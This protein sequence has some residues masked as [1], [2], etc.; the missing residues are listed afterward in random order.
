MEIEMLKQAKKELGYTYKDISRLSG[1]PLRTI[2]D[3]FAE[4]TKPR[5]DTVEA[6][7]KALGITR[8]SV[9]EETKT[10]GFKIFNLKELRK[11]MHKTQQQVANDL[12]IV[13][14][15]YQQYESGKYQPDNE[16]LLKIANYF[17]VSIDYLF[18]RTEDRQ[19]N[20]IKEKGLSE[21]E[22]A[23]IELF[24]QVPQ[25]QQALVLSMIQ[26]ALNNLK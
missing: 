12:N 2:E 16:M 18:G 19:G 20:T 21:N 17:N 8:F 7:E 11:S 24:N 13:Q 15:K 25:D 14:Q 9:E 10:Q 23:L 4:R 26:V 1:V 5:I 3:M 22:Q 6:I